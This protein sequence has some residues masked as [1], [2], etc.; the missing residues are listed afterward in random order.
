MW[1]CGLSGMVGGGM[2]KEEVGKE[3]VLGVG[4]GAIFTFVY[5][6]LEDFMKK[7]KND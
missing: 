1:Q 2:L 3:A 5:C 7:T 6:F 4:V